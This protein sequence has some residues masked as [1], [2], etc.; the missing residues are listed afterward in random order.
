MKKRNLTIEDNKDLGQ[1]QEIAMKSILVFI[2]LCVG[3]LAVLSMTSYFGVKE[4]SFAEEAIEAAIQTS[5][6]ISVDLSPNS[7]E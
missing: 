7:P 2:V 5:T 6:G 1:Y 3:Y 4:D